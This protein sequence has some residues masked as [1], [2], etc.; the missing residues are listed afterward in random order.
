MEPKRSLILDSLGGVLFLVFAFGIFK[1]VYKMILSYLQPSF[2][3]LQPYTP[4]AE[5][6]NTSE[7][8]GIIL[9]VLGGLM[10]G[11]GAII[12]AICSFY[13]GFDELA[14]ATLRT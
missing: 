9:G 6:M 2:S 5:S 11:L 14:Q 4:A 1:S 8:L 10:L 12:L 13:G 3:N 7:W